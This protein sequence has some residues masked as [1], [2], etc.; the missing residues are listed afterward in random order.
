MNPGRPSDW[1]IHP[2]DIDASVAL[3]QNSDTKCTIFNIDVG[4]KLNELLGS[5]SLKQ[6]IENAISTLKVSVPIAE[7]WAKANT[8]TRVP[9][10]IAAVNP[11]LALCIALNLSQIDIE[12]LSGNAQAVTIP[13]VFHVAPEVSVLM[14][15]N[16]KGSANPP[17]PKVIVK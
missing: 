5:D 7:L 9:L 12:Q 6:V 3:G 4:Q 14:G 2:I 13:L 11:Q 8:T 10:D 16:C 1:Y 17:L 15:A